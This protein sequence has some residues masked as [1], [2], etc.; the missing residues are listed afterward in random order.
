MGP[1]SGSS[2]DE[3]SDR[4]GA[5]FAGRNDRIEEHREPSARARAHTYRTMMLENWIGLLAALAVWTILRR[6]V[7]PRLGVPT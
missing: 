3:G 4:F 1:N 6:W 5:G 7:L 2:M